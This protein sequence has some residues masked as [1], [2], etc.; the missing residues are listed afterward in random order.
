MT[1]WHLRWQRKNLKPCPEL[2]DHYNYSLPKEYEESI[3]RL[4][5]LEMRA[6]EAG[7]MQNDGAA[8][9]RLKYI[10]ELKANR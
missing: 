8:L 9:G 4:T 1:D 7:I 5:P 3:Q 2:V 10:N 6:I